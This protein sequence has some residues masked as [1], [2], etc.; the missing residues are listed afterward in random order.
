MTDDGQNAR[1]LTPT[2]LPVTDVAAGEPSLRKRTRLRAVAAALAAGGVASLSVV[3]L[4]APD[5][6]PMPVAATVVAVDTSSVTAQH[7]RRPD[8]TLGATS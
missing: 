6:A 3:L 8:I 1:P 7:V 5:P 2:P 4:G